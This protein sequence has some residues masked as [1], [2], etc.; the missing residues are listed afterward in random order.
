MDQPLLVRIPEQANAPL[1]PIK[2]PPDL[3]TLK[4]VLD[5]LARQPCQS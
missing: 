4:R 2:P 5:G 1:I 3:G